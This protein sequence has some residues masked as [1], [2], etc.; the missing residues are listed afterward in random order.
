M[1]KRNNLL[2]ASTVLALLVGVGGGYWYANSRMPDA[3]IAAVDT[4]PEPL[5]YR[6]PMNPE[7]TSPVPAK[8]NMGMDYIPVYGDDDQDA[9][10]GTVRIDPVTVQNIGVRTALAE[11]RTLSREI[12]PLGR[13]DYDEQRIA[14]L[15]PKTQGWIE[16]LRI[17]TTGARLTRKKGN[18]GT[19]RRK[20]R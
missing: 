13:V 14:R 2:V 12:H 5:F 1:N 7:I 11:R 6:N 15:H 20:R 10:A 8:D 18:A 3:T 16:V 4:G 19:R 9:T 17:G